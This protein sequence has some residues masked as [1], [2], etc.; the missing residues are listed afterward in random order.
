MALT[1]AND[2]SEIDL[3]DGA[4]WPIPAPD[5]IDRHIAEY[6][7][8]IDLI[9]RELD[10]IVA[11]YRSVSIGWLA[12]W[13]EDEA[14]RAI[15]ADPEFTDGVADAVLAEMRAEVLELIEQAPRCIEEVL[16]DD[17]W[18]HHGSDEEILA[19]SRDLSRVPEAVDVGHR[20]AMGLLGRIL[21]DRSFGRAAD[22]TLTA[23]LSA[24]E[25][26]IDDGVVEY[27]FAITLS[28]EAKAIFGDYQRTW[29]ML[30]AAVAE[31]A[32]LEVARRRSDVI[33]RWERLEVD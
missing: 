24:Y 15:T 33:D 19:E 7:A 21:T 30:H 22:A 8:Q 28:D 20:R 32:D 9:R 11:A 5:V 27:P 13:Y 1:A 31:A 18:P 12:Q 26:T 4:A 17:V 23:G 16:A 29:A 14:M 3:R 10:E 2:T 25:W 6:E